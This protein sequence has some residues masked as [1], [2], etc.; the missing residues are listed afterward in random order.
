MK[1]CG[2]CDEIKDFSEDFYNCSRNAD[3]KQNW[4]KQ[5]NSEAKARHRKTNPERY[6][7]LRR[8]YRKGRSLFINEIKQDLKCIKCGESHPAT[9]D[10]H[11]NDPTTKEKSISSMKDHTK[12]KI[13]EEIKKCDILCSNCHRIHHYEERLGL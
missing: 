12:A 10:F 3:G 11:H 7:N 1:Y 2:G 13:L 5:C 4:C 8:N 6:R 9:L